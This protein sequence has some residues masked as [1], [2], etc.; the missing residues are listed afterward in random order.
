MSLAYCLWQAVKYPNTNYI[1]VSLSGESVTALF[2]RLK[3]MNDNLPR[4]KY[5]FPP[6]MRDNRG[7]LLLGNKS[8]VQIAT[9]D[10]KSIGRGNT[11]QYVLLSEFAFY[12]ANEQQKTL[13]SVEQ[14]LAKNP[15]SKLIIETTANGQNY[16]S[17][18]FLKSWK[19]QTNYKAYFYGWTSDAYKE[20][21][22]HEHDIAV[23]WYRNNNKGQRLH[24]SEL[25]E[26]EKRLVNIGANLRMLMW[27]RWKLSSMSLEDFQQEFPGFPEEAFKT[28]GQN[29]FDQGKIL[30]RL[31]NTLPPI[32]IDELR[33]EVPETLSKYLGKG[34]S[35]YHLPIKNKRYYGGS[36]VSSGSGGDSSTLTL[37]DA[38]GEQVLAFQHNKVSVYEFAEILD[39]I[40]KWYNYAFFCIERNSYGLP[41][42]ERLRNEYLYMNLYKHRVFNQRGNKRFELGWLTTEKTKAIMISDF[43]ESFEKGLILINDKDTLQ[44]MILFVEQN[45]K[46]GN[47]KGA[48]NHDDLVISHALSV[49]AMKARKWYV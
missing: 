48:N 28:S 14:A 22:R 21:F 1:I 12:P 15:N 44:Q 49:Q 42:I 18:L 5:K 31:E 17:D 27:R 20:Q 6:T 37:M 38:D 29:V 19:G 36:D 47:R 40:G 33:T 7:E 35:V 11:Y 24:A 23:E 8:R 13:T 30:E 45:G 39:A 32:T 3:L 34:L 43:K 41:V 4:D 9:A 2:E 10:G 46:M 25:D 16:F 26:K